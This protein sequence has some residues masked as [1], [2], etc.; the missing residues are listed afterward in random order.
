M[1]H[2]YYSK[3]R[4]PSQ[5]KTMKPYIVISAGVFLCERMYV[6]LVSFAVGNI[7]SSA[8]RTPMHC[9]KS[10]TKLV[11]YQKLATFFRLLIEVLWFSLGEVVC[12]FN[13][14]Y[15]E[16]L[17]SRSMTHPYDMHLLA[18]Q[19]S[20]IYNLRRDLHVRVGWCSPPNCAVFRGGPWWLTNNAASTTGTVH[21][22]QP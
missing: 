2:I 19:T 12:C 5:C 21:I 9:S 4:I 14:L 7:A 11:P 22:K 10:T 1:L 16:Q 8:K 3:Y 17:I 20:S 18:S 13:T 15:C 6:L